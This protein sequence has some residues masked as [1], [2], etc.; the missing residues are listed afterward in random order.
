VIDGQLRSPLLTD[1][2][3]WRRAIF[4]FPIRMAFQRMDD[5][6]A[7]YGASINVNDKTLELTKDN[8]K[9]WKA[10]F[11]FQRVSESQLTLDGNMDS[12]KVHMQLQLVD[13]KTFL[14]VNRG[15]HWVQEYPFNR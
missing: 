12:H 11:T 7:R 4:E 13:R 3:R 8:D 2:D 9:S 14:L 1:G 10:N 15:F 6:L 5:S